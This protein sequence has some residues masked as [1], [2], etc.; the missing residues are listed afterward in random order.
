MATRPSETGNERLFSREHTNTITARAL[1]REMRLQKVT[2][3]QLEKLSGVPERLIESY[4]SHTEMAAIP[5]CDLLSIASVLGPRFLTG[6]LA[7]INMYASEFKGCSP[8]KI[9]AEI[10]ELA[11]RLTGETA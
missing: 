5:L 10:I 8:E 4:R 11:R 7:E 6:I 9:G 1:G 3:E 2:N